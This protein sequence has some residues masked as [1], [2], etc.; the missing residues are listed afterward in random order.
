M[1]ST[2]ETHEINVSDTQLSKYEVMLY[3]V[4]GG[5]IVT[6]ALMAIDGVMFILDP[7]KLPTIVDG[8]L[9]TAWIGWT[10]GLFGWLHGKNQ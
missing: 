8:V 1:S 6:T 9:G 2:D 4:S 5:Y 3:L 7:T 10:A